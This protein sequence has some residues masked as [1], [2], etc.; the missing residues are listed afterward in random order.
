MDSKASSG[1]SRS[2]PLCS[3]TVTRSLI[4]HLIT[5]HRRTE[6][7]ASALLYR[8]IEGTLG[9]DPE[10]KKEKRRFLLEANSRNDSEKKLRIS[11]HGAKLSDGRYHIDSRSRDRLG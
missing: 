6:P 2:C 8:S 1:E 11:P 9:W 4:Q 5:D 7:E 3:G 10:A